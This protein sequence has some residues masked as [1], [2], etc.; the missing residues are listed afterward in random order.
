M[1]IG[2]LHYF[3]GTVVLTVSLI[4]TFR[5][6]RSFSPSLEDPLRK[7][8]AKYVLIVTGIFC[9]FQ[10]TIFVLVKPPFFESTRFIAKT[11]IQPFFINEQRSFARVFLYDVT[12]FLLIV[13]YST[14]IVSTCFYFSK[15]KHNQS[16]KDETRDKTRAP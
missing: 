6:L 7:V 15:T 14:I 13:F 9:I 11:I 8:K 1:G 12:D 5:F 16:L 4:F 10:S 3:I 2:L